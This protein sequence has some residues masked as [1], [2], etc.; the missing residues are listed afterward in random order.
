M[1]ARGGAAM[2]DLI[3]FSEARMRRVEPYFLLSHGVPRVDERR[4]ISCINF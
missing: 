2:S 4:V 1:A 3:W